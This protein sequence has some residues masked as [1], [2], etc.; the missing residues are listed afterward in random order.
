M[1][2]NTGYIDRAGITIPVLLLEK[3]RHSEN[4]V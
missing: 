2:I 3:P 1:L 4:A